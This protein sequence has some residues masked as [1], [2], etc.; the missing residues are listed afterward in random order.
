MENNNNNI[1]D[2]KVT[3]EQFK[4]VQ[5]AFDYFNAVLFNNELPQVM[6]NF[7]RHN[8]AF[9][10]FAPCQWFDAENDDSQRHEISLN[11]DYLNERTLK[12]SY[13]T[14]V[15]EMCH[16]QQQEDGTAPRRCYHNKDF[17]AKMERVGLMT[18]STGEEGGKRTGQHMTHYIIGGGAFDKAF[19][20]MDKALYLP[21]MCRGLLSPAAKK[22]VK[23]NSSV[24]YVCPVCGAS[25]RGKEGLK[26]ACIDCEVIMQ[27]QG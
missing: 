20:A 1:N 3:T 5:A 24:S 8:K 27:A 2:V 6:L 13:S 18:S 7:S 17:A 21:F 14:L 11:P 10:F 15:H 25:V 19:D 9:G 4:A 26:I 16:L 22:K 12:Q 23:K